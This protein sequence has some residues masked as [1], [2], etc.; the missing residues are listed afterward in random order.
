MKIL[1]TGISGFAGSY[2][3]EYLL[4]IG[5]TNSVGENLEIA[6]TVFSKSDSENIENIKDKL[7]LFECNITDA[8]M[9]EEVISK[10]KPDQIYH[11]AA[12]ASAAD[13]DR[14]KVFSVNVN[15]TL[16]ILEAA[17]KLE[18][19]PKVLLASTGYI[20]GSADK[21]PDGTF[22]PSE[23]DD[24]TKP[25]GLYTESKKEMEEKAKAYF[26]DLDIVITRAFNHTGPRQTTQFVVPAFSEQIAKIEKEEM[27]SVM[28]VGNLEAV[29]DFCDV[30]DVV[31][32]Y[33]D[34]MKLGKPG[35]I[36][37][38]AATKNYTVQEILDRLLTL[39]EKEIRVEKD[40]DRMRKSD[41]EA[42]IGSFKKLNQLSGWEP[43]IDLDKTLLDTLNY[44]REINS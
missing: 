26:N 32:A 5:S 10:Y 36:Y 27:E 30:R 40:P 38:I 13:E 2:L 35:E 34:V 21:N 43:K 20:Y 11:F 42:S 28:K 31:K 7:E 17:K 18:K 14:E 39:S 16:N 22:R 12:M 41:I 9:V 33:A 8:N 19:K 25:Q 23:E 1:I 24:K 44:W 29:R 15:G 37:N 4:K 3:S 6:G